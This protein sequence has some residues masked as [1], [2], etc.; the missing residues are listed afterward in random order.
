M[1]KAENKAAPSCLSTAGAAIRHRISAPLAR[2]RSAPAPVVQHRTAPVEVAPVA[3]PRLAQKLKQGFGYNEAWQRACGLR[4]DAKRMQWAWRRAISYGTWT[5]NGSGARLWALLPCFTAAAAVT[6]QAR[7]QG[8][9]A[10][11]KLSFGVPDHVVEQDA[12]MTWQMLWK[13]QG[14]SDQHGIYTWMFRKCLQPQ[15]SQ[16][17][18]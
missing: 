6:H 17:R 15:W 12:F 18:V 7:R 4:C 16:C 8:P 11:N 3:R 9:W 10:T 13:F 1:R 2:R 14:G 5:G